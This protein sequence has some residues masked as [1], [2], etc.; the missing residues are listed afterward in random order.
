MFIKFFLIQKSKSSTNLNHKEGKQEEATIGENYS[1]PRGNYVGKKSTEGKFPG[2]YC[3]G[4]II[5]E[6]IAWKQ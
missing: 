6:G 2:G 3:Q 4:A 5:F 1:F